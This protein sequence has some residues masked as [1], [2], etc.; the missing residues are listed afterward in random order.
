[1]KSIL[2]VIHVV[3]SI[4]LVVLV[5]IQRGKGADIGAA[6]GSGASQTVFG[7]RGSGSFLSRA[8]AV[9]ATVFFV[10]S[11][12]LAYLT[13]HHE[14]RQSV[15]QVPASTVPKSAPAQD[16]APAKSAAPSDVPS[17]VP[18]APSEN[19]TKPKPK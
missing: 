3:V 10:T 19:N 9:L 17:D 6:F 15:T 13:G 7:S 5:L 1:M 14:R 16:G 11:L 8:T 2:L 4:S 18:A 12:S